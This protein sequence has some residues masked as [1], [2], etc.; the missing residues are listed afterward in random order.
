MNRLDTI[1][2]LVKPQVSEAVAIP[3]IYADLIQHKNPLQN[4]SQEF[5]DCPNGRMLQNISYNILDQDY[6]RN[7]VSV[8]DY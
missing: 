4:I 7:G 8:D 1:L 3:Q 5:E 6:E 2:K